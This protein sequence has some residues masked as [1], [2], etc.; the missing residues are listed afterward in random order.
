MFRFLREFRFYPGTDR[1]KAE[2][3][4]PDGRS[5]GFDLY[6]TEQI[7]NLDNWQIQSL[8]NKYIRSKIWIYITVSVGEATVGIR[9]AAAE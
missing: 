6:S 7:Q 4:A 8:T 3:A 5:S 1:S 9:V 2:Y